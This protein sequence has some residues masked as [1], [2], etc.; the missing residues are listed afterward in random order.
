MGFIPFTSVGRPPQRQARTGPSPLLLVLLFVPLLTGMP[1][2]HVM[3]YFCG[4]LHSGTP[5]PD[6][7]AM[8]AGFWTAQL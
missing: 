3:P 1:P 6:G 8:V 7:S 4:S 5:R 2:R